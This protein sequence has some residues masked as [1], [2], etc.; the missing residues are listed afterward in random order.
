MG[1][2]AWLV[3]ISSPARIKTDRPGGNAPA[4]QIAVSCSKHQSG[5][6]VTCAPANDQNSISA[7][8]KT[9]STAAAASASTTTAAT[10]VAASAT[11]AATT[12]ATR[13]IFSRLGFVDGQCSAV[14]FLPVEGRDRGLS[15][16][17]AA[18][19]NESEALAPARF[20]VA[21]NLGR[22]NGAVRAE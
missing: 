22:L 1:L 10:T 9:A 3:D 7:A 14:M 16:C 11:T 17:I 6:T 13:T 15:L 18:H 20:P 4:R 2:F 5:R 19:L 8:A 12:A 21:D